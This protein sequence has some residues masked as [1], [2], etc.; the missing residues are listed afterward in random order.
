MTGRSIRCALRA[1]F[2]MATLHGA[3]TSDNVATGGAGTGTAASSGTGTVAA[4]SSAAGKGA[5]GG[6][7]AVAGTAAAG[8]GGSAGTATLTCATATMG[9]PATLHAAVV[10]AIIPA[11]PDAKGS[12]AFGSCHDG[13]SKKAMVILDSTSTNLHTLLVD[14][15]ACETAGLKVVDSR[16]G[17]VGLTNSWLWQ[18]LSAPCDASG[19]MV[20]KPEWGTPVNCGQMAGQ[21]FGAR[22]PMS[23]TDT[24]LGA[25]KLAAIR[26]WICAGAPGP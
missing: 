8:S 10:A 5:S 19:V 22:M 16:G 12:C 17:D 7:G 21:A 13:T 6:T 18:K 24:Q 3:C 23:G 11:T 25:D 2:L 15:P 9:A 4:G 26:D 14:K 20:T 1:T